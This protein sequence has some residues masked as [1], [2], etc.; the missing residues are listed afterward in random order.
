MLLLE[1]I[2]L[3]IE[4][5]NKNDLCL[6]EDNIRLHFGQLRRLFFSLHSLTLKEDNHQLK[7]LLLRAKEMFNINGIT[8]TVNGKGTQK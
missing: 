3:S 1:I 2:I 8:N 5:S 6:K 4:L 7:A